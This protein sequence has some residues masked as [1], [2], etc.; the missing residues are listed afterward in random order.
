MILVI[1]MLNLSSETIRH[2]ALEYSASNPSKNKKAVS[3][4]DLRI[5]FVEEGTALWHID[6]LNY[7][8]R[9]GDII[10]LSHLQKRY[11]LESE[12]KGF[13]M[14]I[15]V[16]KRQAFVNTC[17]LFFMLELINNKKIILQDDNL[18]NI[19]K[20]AFSEIENKR[21][22]YFE[23][24]SSKLTEFFV[25]CERKYNF[26]PQNY[27]KPDKQM[28]KILDYID[29]NITEKLTLK[30]MAELSNLTETSF[31]RYFLKC[32]G[33]TFKNYVTTRKIEHAVNLLNNTDTNVIDV[34]YECGFSSISGFYDAFKKVTGTTPNK[35]SDI[36]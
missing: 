14:K 8:V 16:L 24:L 35:L 17:H 33:I 10:L 26:S 19:L 18:L 12:E 31:S 29:S 11:F 2:M 28:N 15:F 21:L 22:G 9:P 13:K 34:A 3:Y 4:N 6:G 20:S 25:L 7:T 32:N 27:T 5:C 23:I 36:I 30:Q 1:I